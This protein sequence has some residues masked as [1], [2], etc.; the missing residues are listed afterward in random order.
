VYVG[1]VVHDAAERAVSAAKNG[2]PIPLLE[3]LADVDRRMRAEFELSAA[4]HTGTGRV[5]WG[6]ER[7][8]AIGLQEHWFKQD[9]QLEPLLDQA[10]HCVSTL[11]RTRVF[12][13]FFEVDERDFLSL[14]TLQQVNIA[15]ITVHVK[16][17]VAMRSLD[18]RGAVIIDWKT[19]DPKRIED[20][21]FQ[22]A[23]YALYGEQAWGIPADQ[24]MALDINLRD[25]GVRRHPITDA[26]IPVVEEKIID[27]T[28]H[29]LTNCPVPQFELLGGKV[30]GANALRQNVSL[31]ANGHFV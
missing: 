29:G 5:S 23:I 1:I 20:V 25:G 27:G 6:G 26:T 14:E 31:S 12:H 10:K 4:G 17:D 15:G 19:G 7:I 18:G 13:R 3:L 24:M 9:I 30:I 28:D 22:L 2:A 8:K 16:L 21:S 11:Y